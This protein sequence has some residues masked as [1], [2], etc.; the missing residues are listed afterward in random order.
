MDKF[1]AFGKNLSASF[2]PFAA[3]TQQYVK[4]QLGQAEDKV[5][6]ASA[7]TQLPPD[8]TELEKRVDALRQVHQKLLQ[9]T[10]VPAQALIPLASK[11]SPPY[12]S[13][14]Y[15]NE[16]YDY[17]PNLR[18]SFND[19]GR[20]ISEKVHL[21]SS[22]TSPAEAQAAFTAPPSAKPQP[23]TF[24]HAIA[25]AS[26]AGSQLLHQSDSS[27]TDDPLATALEKYAIAEEKVGEARLAQD[28]QIQTRFLAG[29]STTLN[30]NLMF[31]QRARKG[32]ENARLSLDATKA[33]AKHGSGFSL[34]GQKGHH[35]KT[36]DELSEE[37]R[38]HI[39]QAEDEFVGQTEEAVGVMKNVLDT[40]EPLRNLADL[41]AAQ[42]EFHKKAYEIL[43][44]LAPI[45]DGLQVEQEAS[46]RKA[47][48]GA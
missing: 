46:Y 25:R 36:D 11:H 19:L 29:W 10:Y 6:R 2:T 27:G 35:V 5:N 26:L 17:P 41:I 28:H 40:P 20:T 12:R 15:S 45:V 7:V 9:V 3:R 33:K 39:E 42:L 34:P 32:V 44:E 47:R 1:Q 43:S 18:E 48:E 23:K 30:T 16:A 22:A 38:V 21:L 13:S 14:Q 31:A 4:E 24:N 8:Y 37:E